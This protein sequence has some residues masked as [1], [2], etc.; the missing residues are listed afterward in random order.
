ML[1][2]ARTAMKFFTWG[3]VAGLLFAPNSGADTR[4]RLKARIMRRG[5]ASG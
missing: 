3:L 1:T 4:E 5:D 2:R